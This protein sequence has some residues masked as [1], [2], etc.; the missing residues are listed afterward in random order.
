LP[1]TALQLAW[2]LVLLFT[3]ALTPFLILAGVL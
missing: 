2:Y 1:M 3:A